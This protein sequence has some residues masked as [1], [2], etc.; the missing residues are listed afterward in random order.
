MK[1][2]LCLAAL[3]LAVACKKETADPGPTGANTFSCRIEGQDFA[4]YLPPVILGGVKAL[5]ARRVNYQ[6]GLVI[7]AQNSFNELT[8]YLHTTQGPGVYILGFAKNPL[9]FGSNPDNYS[10]Y[11]SVPPFIPGVTDP[12]NLTPPTD[13]Y[14]DAANAGTVTITRF[15]TVAHVAGGTF[16]YTARAAAT[17]QVVHVTNGKFDVKF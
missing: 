4:P 8:I 3:L 14:T 6:G 11:T 2:L 17:G 1:K 7:N 9:P 10:K 13:Y 5:D 15:D 12:Y 16:A